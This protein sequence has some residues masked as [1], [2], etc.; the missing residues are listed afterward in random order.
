MKL[1]AGVN[2]E[3]L[4]ALYERI[5]A[6]PVRSRGCGDSLSNWQFAASW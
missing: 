4:L 2:A 1:A 5:V 6:A 3:R